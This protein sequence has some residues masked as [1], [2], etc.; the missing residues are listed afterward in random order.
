M[1][2]NYYFYTICAICVE[3]SVWYTSRYIDEKEHCKKYRNISTFSFVLMCVFTYLEGNHFIP[4]LP[5]ILI[6]LG[7]MNLNLSQFKEKS[8]NERHSDY[9]RENWEKIIKSNN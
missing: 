8:Y 1:E 6:G 5:L 2:V 4:N 9:L 3:I 7:M